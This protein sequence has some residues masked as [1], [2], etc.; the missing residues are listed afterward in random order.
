[1]VNEMRAL[2]APV[3]GISDVV[4]GPVYDPRFPG[5]PLTIGPFQSIRDFHTFLRND[6]VEPPPE[7]LYRYELFA[8]P[9]LANASFHPR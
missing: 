5:T 4:G 6:I 1:M 8:G 7:S 2:P 9:A 3:P